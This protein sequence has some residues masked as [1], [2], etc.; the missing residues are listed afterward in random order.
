MESDDFKPVEAWTESGFN[1]PERAFQSFLA[2]L[3]TGDVT[4]IESVVHWD[5][6]WKETVTEAD[7]QLVEKA[8]RDYL[9][10]LERA[11][12]K[13]AAFRLNSTADRRADRKRVAFTLRTANGRLIDSSFDMICVGG[14]W[15]P[16]LTMGWFGFCTTSVFGPEIDLEN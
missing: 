1:T 14:A 9:Q 3:K 4:R 8:K 2:V 16:V 5:V 6:R 7:K 10:M 11:P 13:I 12:N 15:K